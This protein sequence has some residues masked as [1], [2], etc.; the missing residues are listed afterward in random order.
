MNAAQVHLALNHFPVAGTILAFG[1]LL[2]GFFSKKDQIKTVGIALIIVSAI[3]AV[4][5]AQ[6]GDGAEELVEHKALVTKDIIH[7]HEDAADGAATAIELTAALG[8]AWLVMSRLKKNHLEKVYAVMLITNLVSI[9]MV[10]NAA[11]KGG[12]IRHDEIRDA[13][14]SN[15]VAPLMHQ[16]NEKEEHEKK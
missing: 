12:Q 9:A 3:G 5:V 14:P 11:H 1:V 7:E 6:S 8:I 16:E 15:A 4:V 10:S 13:A 2:W